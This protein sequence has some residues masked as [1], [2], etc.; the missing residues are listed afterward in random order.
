MLHYCYDIKIIKR[1]KKR[2]KKK[3]YAKEERK[4]KYTYIIPRN[5]KKYT[6]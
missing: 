1:K 4:V 3:K 2:Y 5:W 6:N